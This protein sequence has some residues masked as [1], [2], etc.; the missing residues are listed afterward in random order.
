ME[1]TPR[2]AIHNPSRV[3][4]YQERLARKQYRQRFGQDRE[5]DVVERPP[6]LL[7]L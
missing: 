5:G 3:P 6:P 2:T 7:P 1:L 4:T